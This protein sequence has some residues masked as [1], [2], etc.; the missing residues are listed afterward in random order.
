MLDRVAEV[1]RRC[2]GPSPKSLDSDK[3]LKPQ[4]TLFCRDVKIFRDL[5]TFWRSLGKKSAFLGLGLFLGQEVHYYMVYIAY[6]T[7]LDLQICNYA[8]KQ[9]ICCENCKYGLDENFHGHF[10]PQQKAA[11]FC[12]PVFIQLLES[13]IFL[14][15]GVN[16]RA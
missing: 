5:R 13:P 1:V 12:H 10:C 11:N 3:I 16:Y 15:G 14:S 2:E 7:E 6:F 8:Q 9:R 4:H